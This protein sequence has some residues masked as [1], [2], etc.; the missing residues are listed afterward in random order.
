MY[1]YIHIG[2]YLY[3]IIYIYRLNSMQQLSRFV[4]Y[5]YIYV[6]KLQPGILETRLV[7]SETHLLPIRPLALM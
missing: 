6:A 5:I 1:I 3:I 4:I 2:Q 7:L